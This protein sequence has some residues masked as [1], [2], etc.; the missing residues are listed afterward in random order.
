MPKFRVTAPDGQTFDVDAPPGATEA[1]AIEYVKSQYQAKPKG[2]DLSDTLT[3]IDKMQVAGT[4]GDERFDPEGSTTSYLGQQFK[5]GVAATAGMPVDAITNA[6][7]LG[8]AG[9]GAVKGALGGTDLPELIRDPVGGSGTFERMFLTNN[10][11]KP[12]SRAAEVGGRFVRDLGASAL[13]AGAIAS[14]AA[15]PLTSLGLQGG[16]STLA[17]AGGE[18][19]RTLA[20]E[21]YKDVADMA[22]MLTAGVVVPGLIANRLEAVQNLRNATKPNRINAFADDYVRGQIEGDVRNY[23]GAAQNVDDALRM[24]KEIPDLKLRVGQASGVPSLLD[25]ER[26][27]A[28]AGPEQFNRRAVQDAAQQAAIRRA[29]QSRLPLLAGQHDVPDQLATT[30]AQ[31]RALAEMLPETAADD[32]GQV[33]R[34]SRQS[35]K[36]RYDQIAAEKFN[37]PVVAADKLGV[38]VNVDPIIAKT[39]EI[40]QSPIHQ[41]DATNAPAIARRMQSVLNKELPGNQSPIL[42]PEGQPI[43][44]LRDRSF[45][46]PFSELK[47]MR[48]AVNQDIAREAG[49][50]TPNARQ[51][52]RGL[53]EIRG[54]IDRAAQTTPEAVK[55]PYNEAVKWYRDVYAPKFLRGVNLKQSMKDITGE[56]KIPDEKLASQYFKPMGTTPMARFLDLYGDNPQAMKA[57]ESHIL[58][59][60]RRYTVKDGVIDPLKHEAFMRNY[61]P[62]LKKL[63]NTRENFLSIAKASSILAEREAQLS[64]AQKVLS[65][66]QLDAL[67]YEALPDAGLD[68]R[69]VN[70]FLA[71]N[72]ESFSDSVGAIYGQKTA[73]DHLN[74]LRDIAKAAE[75]ADRGRLAEAATPK[76]STSPMS[77]QSGFGFTGRTVFSMIRA[78][79]T[80]RT[81]GEDVA[82][83]LGMQSASHR[84]SKALIAAEERAISDPETAK[85]I[86]DAVKQPITSKQGQLTL[87]KLLAK[88][89]MFLVGGDKWANM[90]KYRAAPFAAQAT[91]EGL[92]PERSH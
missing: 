17:S 8:I 76:Q 7:N 23:P 51:R 78:V 42:G 32:V 40:L 13:P 45:G 83:T 36:G 4:R 82:Y 37:A 30:Q 47:A 14:R 2:N 24:E 85:L 74:N 91:Q 58:D 18:T 81:S 6:L 88:G 56:M 3:Q 61:G 84:V 86:A 92:T 52:L 33:L 26:R 19:A 46:V 55:K 62:S 67:K 71:K 50:A 49:S 87:Q 66:G 35:F 34:Q 73:N 63:P 31:R 20:P 5:K 68:P 77:L 70:T 90:A 69:K 22:G 21:P 80:G 1:Q 48:E 10:D 60:Y 39:S 65:Q 53:L 72:G 28:T 89:G 75:M 59:T 64:N 9:Y 25:M 41:Y 15:S 11:I 44:Q 12:T 43:H 57:M 54:E 79:T 38:K 16:L 29:A 27:V